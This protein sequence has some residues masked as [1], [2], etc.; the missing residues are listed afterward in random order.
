MQ[1]S[2]LTSFG[3]AMSKV[4]SLKFFTYDHNASEHEAYLVYIFRSRD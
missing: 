4:G 3:H 1:V 2:P